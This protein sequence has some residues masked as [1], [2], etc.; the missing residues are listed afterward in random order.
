MSDLIN[1]VDGVALALVD[2][3]TTFRPDQLVAYHKALSKENSESSKWVL[4][5]IMENAEVGAEKR[6]PLCD[7][8]GI[9]HILIEVGSDCVLPSGF[10]KAV[11]SGIAKGLLELPGR[12]MAILGNEMQRISQSKGLDP[13]SDALLPAPF[14]IVPSSP[15]MP[16]DE[17]SITV[18]MYGGGPEIRGKTLRIFHKHSLEVVT[19]EMIEWA[20]EGA[21]LLGCQPCVLS[22]GIGRSNYEAAALSMQAMA[23]G[24]FNVQ[25][26]LEQHITDVVNVS[27]IGSLGL[28]GNVTLLA[29]FIK[30]GEQRASGVRVV[31]MRVGCCFDPRRAVVSFKF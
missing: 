21:S 16:Q 27:G 24:D 20:C 13:A 1:V 23:K 29:T 25:S 2:A 14:L 17:A 30:I 11:E 7:D 8:T 6:L 3:G 19:N 10:V 28:G 26:E 9:P 4:Q 18:L 31:S 12:P 5:Q 22:F 15:D